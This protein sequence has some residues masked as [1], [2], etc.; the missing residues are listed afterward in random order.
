MASKK[1][2]GNSSPNSET[3]VIKDTREQ[4]S[5][6]LARVACK[7]TG[8]H[9]FDIA[10]RIICQVADVQVFPKTGDGADQLM[11]AMAAIREMAPQNSTEAMLAVQ[12]I[13]VHEAALQFLKCATVDDQTFL[14]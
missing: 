10:D 6:E 12:M 8:T 7:L 11:K 9:S 14:V 5:D 3:A 2:S 13:A 1:S 4:V